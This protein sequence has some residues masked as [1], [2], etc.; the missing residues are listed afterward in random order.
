[1]I[2]LFAGFDPR[3]A[4]G[5]HAFCHSVGKHCVKDL[6]SITSMSG[7]QRDGSNRFTYDRFYVPFESDYRGWSI[8]MDGADM[9]VRA[10]LAELYPYG[11]KPVYVVK[12]DYKT[13]HPRKYVGTQMEADNADYPRKN[14]SSFILWNNAH[15]A[16]RVLTPKFLESKD[17]AFLHRF[18]WLNDDQIGE[19]PIEW[20]WL[21]DEYGE[22]Q[23]AKVL[24]W[25]AGIP[26]FY[27]YRAA[28]HCE[29]WRQTVRELMRGME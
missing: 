24:H 27:H 16:N 15:D 19:L 5:F 26:G 13:R 4:I 23:Q 17:G 1:M 11:D 22:N 18:S 3:E 10:D 20:N 8:W 12:H 25:T 2:R 21:A 14:W 7:R 28:P 29:E 9:L 6:V